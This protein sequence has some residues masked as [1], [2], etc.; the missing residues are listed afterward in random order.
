MCQYVLNAEINDRRCMTVRDG[1]APAKCP[2]DVEVQTGVDLAMV[3]FL[4][5]TNPHYF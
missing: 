5:E 4:V 2:S 1:A 3:I